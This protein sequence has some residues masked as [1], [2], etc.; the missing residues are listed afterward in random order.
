MSSASYSAGNNPKRPVGG[1]PPTA[2]DLAGNTTNGSTGYHYNVVL[3]YPW[4]L[5]KLNTV[6]NLLS[7]VPYVTLKEYKVDE[8]FIKNQISFYT[9]NIGTAITDIAEGAVNGV[10]SALAGA[11][12]LAT[13]NTANLQGTKLSPNSQDPLQPYDNLYLKNPST[14]TKNIYTFPYFD[15]INFEINTPPWEAIDALAAAGNIAG[16]LSNVLIGEERTKAASKVVGA[17]GQVAKAALAFSSPKVGIADRPR[18]WS[19]HSPRTINIKFPLFNTINP[20]D[21]IHNRGLCW[22]LVN[23]NLFTKLDFISNVPPV[24]YEISIPGQHYSYAAA[25]TRLTISNK[26]NMRNLTDPNGYACVVPDA[27]EVNMTL[28]DL[29]MPSRNLFWAIQSKAGEV[30]TSSP[31]PTTIPN[32]PT[33]PPATPSSA[34]Q[35]QQPQPNFNGGGVGGG[36]SGSF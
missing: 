16:S 36:A 23:Q 7:E 18:L 34:Q 14:E 32:P 21:W 12:N 8:A 6:S 11:I 3:N 22:T 1:K 4:S 15:D 5:T 29:V 30:T 35:P 33:P 2:A 20:T 26:G 9:G 24:F 31:A 28:E 25:V 13:L 27:Y 19:S 10:T 17:T